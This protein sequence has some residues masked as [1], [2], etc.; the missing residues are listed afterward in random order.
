MACGGYFSA[1][2]SE[3]GELYTWG[4]LARTIGSPLESKGSHW[5][6]GPL[7]GRKKTAPKSPRVMTRSL[8]SLAKSLVVTKKVTDS[9]YGAFKDPLKLM[10]AARKE[11]QEWA[12][13]LF[14]SISGTVHFQVCFVPQ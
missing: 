11:P 3:T 12:G 7:R 6:V 10:E 1:A 9:R 14:F 4:P 8:E 13:G 2:V 5:K